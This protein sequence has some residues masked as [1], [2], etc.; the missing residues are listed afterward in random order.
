MPTHG[1]ATRLNQVAYNAVDERRLDS[2]LLMPGPASQPFSSR[3]GKRVNG[4][5][6]G[7]SVSGNP[8]NWFVTPGAGVIFDGNYAT[9]GPWRVEI[10][11]QVS[12]A[13]PPRPATGQSRIDLIVARIY[14]TDAIGSGP[15]DVVVERVNGTAGTS[16]SAPAT[17][18][19]SLLLATL[20]VP[21]SGSITV[22]PSTQVTVA[23]GGIL[24]VAT[25]AERD[26]LVTAGI[27]Y[28]GMVVDNGQT[29]RLE[30]YNG[31]TWKGL[32]EV[33]DSA[34]WV[35]VTLASGYTG[36]V[37]VCLDGRTV[38]WSG[39]LNRTAGNFPY[40][41]A[42]VGQLPSSAYRPRALTRAIIPGF[43]SG[44]ANGLLV[45]L[46]PTTNDITM[47]GLGVSTA[48]AFFGALSHSRN[49]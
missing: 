37:E 8:E 24:P 10:P 29:G 47:A 42:V 3:S 18:A 27:A 41:S 11:A 2:A 43:A 45:I 17:P 19:L 34:T 40:T 32:A 12:G 38:V 16:P 39:Q 20:T 25:T 44:N 30:R 15:R 31:T 26:A 35:P 46:S 14:D 36:T 1:H 33:D 7:V 28:R 5:G 13:M 6:L 49:L 22:A 21:N 48:D 23:A 4:A 9:Q